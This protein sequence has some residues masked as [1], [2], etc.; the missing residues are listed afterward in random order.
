[1]W[2]CGYRPLLSMHQW[3]SRPLKRCVP[4]CLLTTYRCQ[5][6]R[7]M[8]S[9]NSCKRTTQKRMRRR[10]FKMTVF[11]N[12]TFTDTNGVLLQNHTPAVGEIWVKR[13]TLPNADIQ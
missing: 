1:M 2:R 13:D 12:D 7:G 6:R 10:Y 9:G 4:A 11:V 5:E 8:S 3:H